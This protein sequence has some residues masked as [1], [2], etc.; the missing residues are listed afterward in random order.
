M[1]KSKYYQRPDGL[2]E[3][4]RMINGKRVAFRGHSCREV[5]RKILEYKEKLESGRT[6]K[7]VADQWQREREP[8]LSEAS[9]KAYKSPMKEL[10]DYIGDKPVKDVKPIQLDRY[11][12]KLKAKGYRLGS[13]KLCLTVCKQV[14]RFAVIQGDIDVSPAAEIQIP[15]K[16][17]RQK[18]G[19]LTAE[20]IVQVAKYRGPGYLMGIA[21]LFTGCRRG[22]LMGLRYEDIDR[23]NK[24]INVC[25]KV[26]YV[27]GKAVLED[28]TKTE[29]GMRQ[30]PLLKPLEDVLPVGRIGLIF[31]CEDGGLMTPYAI[32][33]E[34][35]AFIDGCG[36]PKEITPH[37]MRHTFA[38]IC[39]DAGLDPKS[40]AAMMGHANESI[41][42]EIYT[43]LSKS[44][45]QIN[46]DKLAAY[47]E[48]ETAA[49]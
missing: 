29:A 24:T 11:M 35:D 41:T 7:E 17:D 15:G 42:M 33:N 49:E 36:L 5:D 46:A 40:T 22:E 20:Q 32:K 14:F 47:L 12:L 25:R 44:R 13:V 48:K 26:S 38:T 6:V 23:K 16:L 19:S 31:H 28:H 3:S 1:A 4:I 34:W 8:H 37:W 21:F 43:H 39:Y 45:E 27:T 9:R 2:F 18:R 10:L 30:I